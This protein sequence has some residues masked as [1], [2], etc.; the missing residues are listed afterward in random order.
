MRTGHDPGNT[1][2]G[3]SSE[4]KRHQ[5]K[6]VVAGRTG[7]HMRILRFGDAGV[8]DVQSRPA[9]QEDGTLQG[10]GSGSR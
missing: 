2:T 7:Q 9:A 4:P 3:A 8:H 1:A 6:I 10:G 5:I